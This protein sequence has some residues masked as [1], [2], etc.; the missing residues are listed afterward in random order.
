VR[1]YAKGIS[2]FHVLW[3]NLGMAWLYTRLALGILPRTCRL[4]ARRVALAR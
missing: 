1:H 2:H 3:Y 4:L